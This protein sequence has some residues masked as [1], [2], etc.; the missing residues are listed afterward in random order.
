MWQLTGRKRT[1]VVTIQLMDIADRHRFS[2][3]AFYLDIAG[4]FSTCS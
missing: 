1:Y 2:A 3:V 4:T